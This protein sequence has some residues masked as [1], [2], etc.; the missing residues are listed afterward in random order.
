MIFVQLPKRII[1]VEDSLNFEDH[2]VQKK[3]VQPTEEAV[4]CLKM[5]EDPARITVHLRIFIL[6][7]FY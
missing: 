6:F 3:W 2:E 7:Y 4:Q 1:R 5:E